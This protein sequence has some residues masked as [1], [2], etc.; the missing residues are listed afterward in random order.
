MASM[1]PLSI[2]SSLSDIVSNMSTSII[3]RTKGLPYLEKIKNY[4]NMYTIDLAVHLAQNCVNGSHFLT[5]RVLILPK[6]FDVLAMLKKYICSDL[7]ILIV[8]FKSNY[9]MVVFFVVNRQVAIVF[10]G[11]VKLAEYVST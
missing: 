9:L 7:H 1:R 2:S 8:N 10:T 11:L 5:L 4:I 6:R 3:S